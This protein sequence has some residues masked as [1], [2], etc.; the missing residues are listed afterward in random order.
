MAAQPQIQSVRQF[1]AD[2][3]A[4][5][6]FARGTE[7]ASGFGSGRLLGAPTPP[8]THSQSGRYGEQKHRLLD[9][10]LHTRMYIVEGLSLTAPS[11]FG[12]NVSA[13]RCL[14]YLL[15]PLIFLR[16]FVAVSI[17]SMYCC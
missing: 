6:F 11:K 1:F 10:G 4:A 3:L 12:G 7:A 2:A 5:Y 17:F 15:N 9:C 13:G 8:P 16:L 14:R